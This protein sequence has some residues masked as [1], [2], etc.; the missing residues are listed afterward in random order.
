MFER[1]L[2][3]CTGNICRSPFAQAML[4]ELMPAA[5]VRS[6]GIATDKSGLQGFPAE[7]SMIDVAKQYHLD[8]SVHAA[9]QLTRQDCHWSDV[10]FIMHPDQLNG[11]ANIS[12][13]ARGKTFLLGQWDQGTIEDPFGQSI[14]EYQTAAKQIDAAC[15]AWLKK[16]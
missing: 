2:I 10:I 8:L 9:R 12:R 3:V 4:Q 1:V 13:S 6:A 15:Q 14:A 11:V 7:K 16:F 5:E